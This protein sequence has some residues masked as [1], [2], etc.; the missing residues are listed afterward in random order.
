[1]QIMQNWNN[2]EQFTDT[3]QVMTEFMESDTTAG[4]HL[5]PSIHSY[6]W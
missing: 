6:R 4:S 3:V 5:V 2:Q 1:M